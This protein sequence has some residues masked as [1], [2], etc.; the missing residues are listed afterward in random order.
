MDGTVKYV[1]QMTPPDYLPPGEEFRAGGYTFRVHPGGKEVSTHMEEHEFDHSVVDKLEAHLHSYLDAVQLRHFKSYKLKRD[2]RYDRTGVRSFG[3]P[4]VAV[5]RAG[6]GNVQIL[7]ADGAVIF[8]AKEE[9]ARNRQEVIGR[10]E[11][12]AN[13]LS[14]CSDDPCLRS[15][16]SSFD[17]A[18]NDQDNELIHL[19]EIRDAAASRFSGGGAAREALGIARNEWDDFHKICNDRG[20]AQDRHRGSKYA[21]LRQ[22]THEELGIARR[23]ARDLIMRYI[24]YI[25]RTDAF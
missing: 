11:R 13:L 25:E 14:R 24:A 17:Q 19:Y 3:E 1:W 18:C 10:L 8:D 20:L 23:F 2:G 16:R 4:A 6:V 9:E 15:M 5:A 7:N 22:A 12:D 21:E